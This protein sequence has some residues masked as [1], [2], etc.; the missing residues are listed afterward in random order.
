MSALKILAPTPEHIEQAAF[1]LKSGALVG[2]PTETVYGLAGNAL[3]E[4]AVVRIFKSK[5]RPQFDP[6]I[7]HVPKNSS[8]AEMEQAGWVR[9]SS[10]SAPMRSACEELAK[11]FWPGP[12]TLV[13]PKGARV[14]DLVTSG[15]ET[16][17]IRMPAHPVAQALIAA[18]GFPLAAPSANRFG[19][20]SP[21]Q[22]EAVEQEL[23]DHVEWILDGGPCEVGVES[24]VLLA[25]PDERFTLLR[26]GKITVDELREVL[27]EKLATSDPLRV[28]APQEMTSHAPG[29]QERHYAP[30]KPC[31]LLPETVS[32][33][34]PDHLERM[35]L[36]TQEIAQPA[37]GEFANSPGKVGLLI[38]R[39][40]AD[41]AARAFTQALGLET[42]CVSLSK[43][44]NEVEAASRL[45]RELRRL[46]QSSVDAIFCEP[47]PS[48]EGLWHAI[49]DRIARAT[50]PV[51]EP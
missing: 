36:I 19:R 48:A 2:M 45:F 7:V 37:G 18:A 16:V 29:R 22:A 46:D 10:L 4:A 47:P 39:G 13:V 6:L 1:A 44:G 5:D 51:M 32:K 3:D 33:L 23:G 25:G 14:P 35:R 8:F 20:I 12:L 30:A 42:E 49:S 17:G 15:L 31:F 40:R 38:F 21:T 28:A 27:A 26:P 43:M 50:R 24:T 34:K 41:T 11:R 9:W